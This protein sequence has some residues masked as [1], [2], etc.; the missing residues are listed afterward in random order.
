[1]GSFRDDL[2]PDLDEIRGISD[3]LGLRVFSVFV[4]R[5]TWSGSRPGMGN[6]TPGPIVQL[7]NTRPDGSTAP[8]LVRQVTSQDIIASGGV[9]SDG[10]YKVG[11][12]TP[13]Y[14]GGGVGDDALDPTPTA[15]P[16]QAVEIVWTMKGPGLPANGA[17]MKKINEEATWA[18]SFLMLRNTG[19]RAP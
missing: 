11:P 13:P 15:T 3:E 8:V 12:M 9:Y 1:M 17:I 19:A 14:P 4:Q 6:V 10:D 7:V 18:H 2:L 16:T 5:N